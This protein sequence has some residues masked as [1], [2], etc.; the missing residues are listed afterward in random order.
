MSDREEKRFL[1][2]TVPWLAFLVVA[3][4][5]AGVVMTSALEAH[6]REAA[7]RHEARID[8]NGTE[9]GKTRAETRPPEL[10]REPMR[11]AVQT[12]IYVDR[13]FDVSLPDNR[14]GVDFYI[15]FR[16]TDGGI[17]PGDDF[18]V[19]DG[20]IRKKSLEASLQ[21]GNT[22]YQLYRVEAEITKFFSVAR[23]PRDDHLLTIKIEDSRYQNYDLRYVADDG[24][25]AMSS[26]AKVLGYEVYRTGAVV[27][28]HSYKT[29]RGDPR[30]P[31][32]YKATYSQLLFGIWIKRPGWGLYVKMFV[33]I[34]AAI[35]IALL[36][37]FI[38][39][40]HTSPRFGVG[41]GAFFAGVASNYVIS[42][43]LPQS[44]EIGLTDFVTGT[45]L[46]TMF[47]MLL[48]S[49]ISVRFYETLERPEVVR[50]FDVAAFAVFLVANVWLTVALARAAS[51]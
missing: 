46:I 34:F 35:S 32:D 39:P 23:F 41:V 30:L 18:Q 47:L 27:K 9:R 36:V 4:A 19:V 20:V 45:I 12:G 40:N 43:Q 44:S 13:V 11:I 15:W 1:A 38:R 33:G 7:E 3:Y 25:S 31:D 17:R 37:F 26:R 29:R 16:W 51:I 24:G 2:I 50:R 48:S 10:D 49:V 21:E 42:R 14:W 28:D 5:I 22:H 6:K 8:P